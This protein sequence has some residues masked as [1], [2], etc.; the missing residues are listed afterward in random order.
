MKKKKI[1]KKT[2][3]IKN[4]NKDAKDE[5][6]KILILTISIIAFIVLLVF[7]P[8]NE[9]LQAKLQ[10]IQ[11]DNKDNSEKVIKTFNIK[12]ED[13]IELEE[14]EGNDIKIISIDEEDIV[15]SRDAKRYE[16]I[17]QDGP[18]NGEAVDYI[19]T[20]IETIEYEKEFSIDIDSRNPFGPVYEQPRYYYSAKFTKK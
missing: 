12:E 11:F 4:T 3:E 9:T 18:Y 20:V 15:I 10:I 7:F 5:L 16:I 2:K 17:R 13:L 8:K 14:Y 1:N 19:Q 6:T